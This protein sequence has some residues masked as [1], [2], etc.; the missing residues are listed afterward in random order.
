[1]R[2]PWRHYLPLEKDHSNMAPVVDVIRDKRRW[3]EITGWARDEVALNPAYSYQAMVDSVDDAMAL[4]VTGRARLEAAPFTAL[5]GRSFADMPHT[6][7]HRPGVPRALNR[8]A[9]LLARAAP[10]VTPSAT[11]IAPAAAHESERAHAVRAAI[12]RA[13]AFAFWALRPSLLTRRD[14]VRGGRPLLEDLAELRRLQIVGQRAITTTDG[15]PYAVVLD[16]E[17]GALRIV[18]RLAGKLSDGTTALPDDISWARSLELDLDDRWLAP[19]DRPERLH[20]RLDPLSAV[21]ATRPEAIRRLIAG[22][23]PW[24]EIVPARAAA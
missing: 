14:L 5:A 4:Q 17:L 11:N 23:A 19:I 24:C 9:L 16:R 15:S 7:R 22:D 1:M 20:R 18:T 3:T 13:R 8:L 2:Q 6:K 12:R 10:L 21:L